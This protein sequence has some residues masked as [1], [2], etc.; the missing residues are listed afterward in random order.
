TLLDGA[1]PGSDKQLTF[2]RSMA[3][4]VGKRIPPSSYGG[5]ARSAEALDFLAGLLDGTVTL[6]GLTVGADL[7]WTLLTALAARGR[8]DRDRVLAELA[9]DNTI[10]GKERAA[11]ALAVIPSTESKEEAWQDAAVR[12]GVPNETQRSIAYVFDTSAQHDEL[13]PYLERYLETAETIWEDKGTQIASTMLEY[14]FPRALAGRETLERV[15]AWLAAS[16]ANPAAKRYVVEGR[17]DVARALR[18]REYNAG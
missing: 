17:D 8:A 4:T 13:A 3:G 2:V 10:S 12:D 7:R 11:A 14:M 5:S 6:D 15:D 18:T 1:A 16:K 9:E